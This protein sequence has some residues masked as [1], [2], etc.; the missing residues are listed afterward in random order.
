MSG[1]DLTS[2][3]APSVA[4]GLPSELLTRRPDVVTAE[5]NLEGANANLAAARAALLP[6][7]S[8]TASGGISTRHA[9]G[10]RDQSHLHG[11][12]RAIHRADDLRC[13]KARGGD[14]RSARTRAG[15]AAVLSQHGDQRVLGSGDD[16]RID[17]QSETRKRCTGPSRRRNRRSRSTSRRR[18][19]A[20]ASTTSWSCWMRSGRCISHAISFSRRVSSNCSQLVALYKA[21]GGGWEDPNATV[22]QQ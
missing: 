1:R 10:A 20:R 19:I 8:L 11:R 15:A 3:E 2:I 13:R 16:A 22:A 6:S 18:A 21:L 5:A 9:D 4:P 7:I 12:D 14:R 17:R